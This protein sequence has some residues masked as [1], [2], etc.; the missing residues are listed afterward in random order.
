MVIIEYSGVE[1]EVEAEVEVVFVFVV[2]FGL[3][4]GIYRLSALSF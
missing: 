1:C 2:D 4:I 3:E